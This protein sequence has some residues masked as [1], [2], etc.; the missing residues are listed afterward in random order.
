MKEV[1]VYKGKIKEFAIDLENAGYDEAFI[2]K[3]RLFL[4]LE[5]DAYQE[6]VLFRKE[7]QE[8]EKK[9]KVKRVM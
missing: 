9:H 8:I 1:W 3:N 4:L 5:A 6:M 7:I 2:R